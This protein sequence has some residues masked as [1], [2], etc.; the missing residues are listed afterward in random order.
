MT[1]I[2]FFEC[3]GLKA[4]QEIQSGVT[5]IVVVHLHL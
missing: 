5:T 3:N 1:V 2:H 4:L